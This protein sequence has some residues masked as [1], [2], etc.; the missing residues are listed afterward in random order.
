MWLVRFCL[1]LAFPFVAL[2]VVDKL[3]SLGLFA[4]RCPE[5]RHPLTVEERTLAEP[6]A[7]AAGRGLRVRTCPACGYWDEKEFSID[8]Y[9]GCVTA[10]GTHSLGWKRN[11][12]MRVNAETLRRSEEDGAARRAG[13]GSRRWK[14]T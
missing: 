12:W 13:T 8:R 4:P 14:N 6:T 10:E 11:E 9:A 1:L 5:C 7:D 3:K 2:A